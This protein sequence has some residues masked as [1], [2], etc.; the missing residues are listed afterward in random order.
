MYIMQAYRPQ[1]ANTYTGMRNQVEQLNQYLNFA[2]GFMIFIYL[3]GDV[4]DL[5]QIQDDCRDHWMI[6]VSPM[7][8]GHL[9]ENDVRHQP[10][11]GICGTTSTLW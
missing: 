2:S 8:L 7:A 1:V 9:R 6:W 11:L 4:E 3:Y 5:W 10:W